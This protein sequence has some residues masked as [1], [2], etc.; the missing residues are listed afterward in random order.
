MEKNS[1]PSC[2]SSVVGSLC[3]GAIAL[4][5][6]FAYGTSHYGWRIYL[7]LFSHFQVQY[8]VLALLLLGCLVL[9][10]HKGLMLI[11]L[12]LC[13][14]LSMQVLPWYAPPKRLLT[15][16]H[17][18][19]DLRVFIA[20]LN[21]QNTRYEDVLDIV[22]SEQPNVA[23]FMEVDQAWKETFD[24]LVDIL[25]YSSGQTNPFNLGL[26]VY[27]D[28]PLNDTHIE[29]FGTENNTSVVTQLTVQNQPITLIATHPV[30]PVRPGLFQSRNRQLDLII[31]Y[32]EPI[33]NRVIL[34][35][36]LNITMWSPYYR[37]LENFTGL[38]NARNGFGILP[39]WPTPVIY[40]HIPGWF[41]SLFLI[42]ID[43]CLLSA[44]WNVSNIRTGA[45][46]GSDH[47][48]LVVDLELANN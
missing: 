44:D 43:H 14:L 11:G 27:S 22:R 45:E 33:Q 5:S 13:T 31:Q 42:P 47:R 7:E 2:L 19:A 30:P 38:H 26:L 46:T 34:A 25:P 12:F 6:L 23:I 29:F 18:D 48:S 40:Q 15:D 24:T 41:T 8:L 20:N 37:R 16:V 35:G 17:A 4:L 10:R 36:D 1:S 21:T 9:L 32:L 28:I 3:V 39:T